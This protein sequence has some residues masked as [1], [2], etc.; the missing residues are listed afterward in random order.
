LNGANSGKTTVGR[1]RDPSQPGVAVF[2]G[3]KNFMAKW[4]CHALLPE[5]VMR[6][7]KACA[8]QK[9]RHWLGVEK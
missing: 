9:A 8:L 2:S 5:M 6:F 4:I 1:K 3:R 7:F